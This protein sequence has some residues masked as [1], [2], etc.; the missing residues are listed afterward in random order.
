ML[1]VTRSWPLVRQASNGNVRMPGCKCA[2]DRCRLRGTGDFCPRRGECS[3]GHIAATAVTFFV[4]SRVPGS[5]AICFLRRWRG[6]KGGSH[7]TRISLGR[8]FVPVAVTATLVGTAWIGLAGGLRIDGAFAQRTESKEE[9]DRRKRGERP[10]RKETP[11]SPRGPGAASPGAPNATGPQQTAPGRPVRPERVDPRAPSAPRQVA[12]QPAPGAP[13]SVGRPRRRPGK[14]RL[15]PAA[16]CPARCNR[17]RVHRPRK[18]RRPRDRAS[19]RW[20]PAIRP[21][22]TVRAG[23]R[24]PRR[25]VVS[26]RGGRR[27]LLGAPRRPGPTSARWHRMIGPGATARSA[28]VRRGRAMASGRCARR[29][30]PVA[31]RLPV[32]PIVR[33]HPVSRRRPWGADRAVSTM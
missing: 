33:S 31:R 14:S 2:R 30:R 17:R 12:P 22:A 32:R 28:M 15:S 29:S 27:S 10:Q 25:A 16:T 21:G 20:H 9:E 7:M 5:R 11:V 4:L 19:V 8:R 6:C 24:R 23:T 13:P 18:V 3:N 26:A 1:V